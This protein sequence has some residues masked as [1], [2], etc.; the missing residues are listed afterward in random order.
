M[1][2]VAFLLTIH[3][4][5]SFSYSSVYVSTQCSTFLQKKLCFSLNLGVKNDPSLIGGILYLCFGCLF[6]SVSCWDYRK[7]Q[8]E[9]ENALE[10]AGESGWSVSC[11]ILFLK[12]FANYKF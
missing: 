6:F 10:R 3:F 7:T 11:K 9:T 8:G 1:E 4:C 5:S 12:S 2:E